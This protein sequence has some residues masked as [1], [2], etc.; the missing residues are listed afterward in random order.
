MAS[1]A[2][3]IPCHNEEQTVGRVVA[4]ARHALPDAAVYVFDNN[5]TD[6]TAAVAEEAGAVVVREYRQGKGNVLR[7]MFRTIEA[8]CYLLVD[9]DDTY[10]LGAASRMVELVMS[11]G[12]D[13]VVGDRLSSS[14]F[15]ENKRR[16]HNFGNLLM[17][18]LVNLLF[19]SDQKDIMSGCRA[20]SR[21]FVKTFPVLSEGF[22]IE[23]EMTIHAL[24]K[25]FLIRE[26]PIGYRDRPEGSVS[27]LNTFRDG[28]RVIRTA[29]DLF[30]NYRPFHFFGAISLFLMLISLSLF[31]PIFIDF[32]DTAQVPRFPT[33]IVSSGLG[34]CSLLSFACGAILDSMRKQSL[35]HFELL[36]NAEMS[37][38][39]GCLHI[40]GGAGRGVK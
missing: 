2:V 7:S 32:L 10:D 33:L 23:T 24:D 12:A 40:S 14:Y 37:R 17:R 11:G 35:Q 19:S 31:A 27:K 1:I 29:F 25:R 13:M 15:T 20:F 16:F 26:I 18:F 28:F 21:I 34:V 8:D 4:D 36:I 39:G 22:E 9:G 6:R 3:L 30:K 5:S 38:A